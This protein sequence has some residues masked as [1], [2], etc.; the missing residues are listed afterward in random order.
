M[1]DNEKTLAKLHPPKSK[2]S[3]KE[4]AKML[5]IQKLHN[6]ILTGNTRLLR[7]LETKD[8]QD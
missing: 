1:S 6:A 4:F 8:A 2:V 7:K 5:K 3:A